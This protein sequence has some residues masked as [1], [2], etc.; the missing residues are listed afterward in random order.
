MEKELVDS[1]LSLYVLHGMSVL[2]F[3]LQVVFVTRFHEHLM[4]PNHKD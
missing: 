3:F 4:L 2:V 1:L